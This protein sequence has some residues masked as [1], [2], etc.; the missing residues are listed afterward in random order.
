MENRTILYGKGSFGTKEWSIWSKGNQI[1]IEANNVIYTETVKEGKA[2]RSLA[3]QVQLRMDARIRGKLDSGFKRSIEE[4]GA[5]NTNQLGYAMPMLA[6]KHTDVK[7][8]PDKK[9]L[10][11]PKFNGH[12]CLINEDGAYSRRGKPIETIKEILSELKVPDGVTLDGELYCHGMPLQT[13][14][15]WAKR[16]QANTSKLQFCIYDAIVPGYTFEE[17]Y[18]LLEELIVPTEHIVLVKNE[19]FNH[20]LGATYYRDKMIN[21]GFEGAMLRYADSAYE[22]GTRSKSLIKVKFRFDGEFKCIG[23]EPSREGFGILILE[24][25]SGKTFKAMAPGNHYDK[26]FVLTN[27][28]DYINRWVTCQWPEVTNEG[29]PFHCVATGWRRDL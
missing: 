1:F 24:T 13:I 7:I 10:V 9:I 22:I 15:S 14:A 23:I 2:S 4:L 26:Q 18:Q 8:N 11:Q 21:Q 16:R 27:K 17:R 25:G 12:R 19:D 20:F 6:V 29:I 5:H 3:E 28:E